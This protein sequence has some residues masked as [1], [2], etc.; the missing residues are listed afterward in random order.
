[1]H[2]GLFKG[3]LS[4][5]APQTSYVTLH[6]VPL[7]V[8]FRRDETTMSVDRHCTVS[9]KTEFAMCKVVGRQRSIDLF[10]LTEKSKA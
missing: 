7:H 4:H 3:S 9:K 10:H 6:H 1:M 5:A 8:S 2:Q